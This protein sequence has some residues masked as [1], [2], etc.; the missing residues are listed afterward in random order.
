MYFLY[1]DESGDI[2]LH[3]SPSRYFALSGLVVHEL[4]WHDVL[5]EI[6]RFRGD[7]R[8][9]YGLKL[10]DEIHT[11]HFI[12]S[13]GKLQCIR[14]DIRLRILREVLDFQSQLPSV[15]II[16][17]IADKNKRTPPFDLFEFTW[18]SLI[19]R[20]DNTINYRNFPGPKNQKDH[21][22][23]IVD[24]TDEPKLRLL[25]RRMRRYNPVPNKIGHGYRNLHNLTLV[26]D[27][28]HRDSGHS[29]FIQ[30]A[31]VNAYF[32]TQKFAPC[33]Y[34]RKKRSTQLLRPLDSC[35]ANEGVAT[36]STGYRSTVV[37]K[38]RARITRAR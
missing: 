2:G 14:K 3:G 10:R 6:I 25:T 15:S 4:A 7:V 12:H 13:P 32:L 16:N 18:K 1:V 8:K 36:G 17:V 26:E 29:Y 34:I 30:L 20:F 28:V 31:D 37:P 33:K 5:N 24:R 35:T 22:L 27:A 19:Q 9:R 11:A 21:G 23:L 38:S